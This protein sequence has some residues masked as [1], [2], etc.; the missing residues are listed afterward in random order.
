MARKKN[1]T[2][3]ADE[4]QVGVVVDAPE[5]SGA[6]AENAAPEA[7]QFGEATDITPASDETPTETTTAVPAT[8]DNSKKHHLLAAHTNNWLNNR[9][10]R[11]TGKHRGNKALTIADEI[12]AQICQDLDSGRISKGKDG[13]VSHDL[14]VEMIRDYEAEKGFGSAGNPLDAEAKCHLRSTPFGGGW[15]NFRLFPELIEVEPGDTVTLAQLQEVIDKLQLEEDGEQITCPGLDETNP[16]GWQFQPVKRLVFRSSDGKQVFYNG[17]PVESGAFVQKGDKIVGH[18]LRCQE[19]ANNRAFRI[20]KQKNVKPERIYYRPFD[21]VQ[22]EIDT[23]RRKVQVAADAERRK[24][25]TVLSLGGGK[26]G[27]ILRDAESRVNKQDARDRNRHGHDRSYG[28]SHHNKD[29]Q[30]K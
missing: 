17:K 14:V 15:L 30:W 19:D 28:D 16:C 21:V 26:I 18:C 6:Q 20:A 7:P 5:T 2:P 10:S 8:N 13:F 23:E 11:K 27:R 12:R 4:Q 29:R 3:A 25:D 24:N 1:V 9:A 22:E